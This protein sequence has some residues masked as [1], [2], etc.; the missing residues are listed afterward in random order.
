M[1]P[2]YTGFTVYMIQVLEN[3]YK[4]SSKYVKD[5]TNPVLSTCRRKAVVEL[6][7]REMYVT[8]NCMREWTVISSLFKYSVYLCVYFNYQF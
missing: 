1:D 6:H 5:S 2:L 7:Y 4:L 3:L 8:L